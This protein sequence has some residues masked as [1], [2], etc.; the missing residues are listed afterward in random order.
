MIESLESLGLTQQA[1]LTWMRKILSFLI[2][3]PVPAYHTPVK[4]TLQ[5]KIQTCFFLGLI[6]QNTKFLCVLPS[7]AP[8]QTLAKPKNLPHGNSLLRC[9]AQKTRLIPGY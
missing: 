6:A 3:I 2:H 5:E 8:H 4:H 1:P 9:E 7:P